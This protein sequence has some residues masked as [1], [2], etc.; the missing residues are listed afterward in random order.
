[1]PNSAFAAAAPLGFALT[2]RRWRTVWWSSAH[3]Y[4]NAITNELFLHLSAALYNRFGG[5]EYLTNAKKVRITHSEL[6]KRNLTRSLFTDLEL[7]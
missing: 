1:M 7:A 3:T 5:N 2:G 4:K 6:K